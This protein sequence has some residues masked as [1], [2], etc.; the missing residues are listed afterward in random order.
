MASK[1]EEMILWT[2]YF[3][4]KLTRSQGRRVPKSASI[5]NPTLETLVWAARTTGIRKMRQEPETSHPSRPYSNEGRIV[6][7][8][9]HALEV[10]NSNSK[11]G[12]MQE[13]GRTLRARMKES[14]IRG[15]TVSSRNSR[16]NIR[17]RS[18]RKSFKNKPSNKRKNKFG[19]RR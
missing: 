4:S 18:Q 12:V 14:Q 10:T 15:D 19:K 3:D 1:R 11:E 13:I 7:P 6:L 17:Q 2:R 5:P 9:K 8:P 16:G